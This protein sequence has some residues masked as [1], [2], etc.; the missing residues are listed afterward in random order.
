MFQDTSRSVNGIS[1]FEEAYPGRN[2][3]E[4]EREIDCCGSPSQAQMKSPK[5]LPSGAYKVYDR[6]L[7]RHRYIPRKWTQEEFEAALPGRFKSKPTVSYHDSEAGFEKDINVNG[8]NLSE[9]ETFTASEKIKQP[10]GFSNSQTKRELEEKIKNLKAI[11]EK[12]GKSNDDCETSSNMDEME[13]TEKVEM[14]ETQV[15]ELERCK[16]SE[17]KVKLIEEPDFAGNCDENSEEVNTESSRNNFCSFLNAFLRCLLK[18]ESFVELLSNISGNNPIIVKLKFLMQSI[19]NPQQLDSED[20]FL[21]FLEEFSECHSCD[22]VLAI[23]LET[24]IEDTS[25]EGASNLRS[26]IQGEFCHITTCDSCV[27]IAKDFEPFLFLNPTTPSVHSQNNRVFDI[28]FLTCSC[29]GIWLVTTR[30]FVIK[31]GMLV[32]DLVEELLSCPEFNGCNSIHIGEVSGGRLIET[33]DKDVELSTIRSNSDIFAFNVLNFSNEFAESSHAS[34]STAMPY[35]LYYNCGLCLSDG[36][37]VGL[38]THK[39]CGG[40]ICRD[41]LDMITQ[42]YHEWEHCPC[43]IC[44]QTIDLDKELCRARMSETREELTPG[45]NLYCEVMFRADKHIDGGIRELNKFFD[46][47]RSSTPRGEAKVGGGRVFK[48]VW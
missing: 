41:C 4:N 40:M 38:F 8:Y 3:I 43:P 30:Q 13:R 25:S 39:K 33:F 48:T 2:E 9:N 7:E 32:N 36:K 31:P 42:S 18:I 46:V 1:R 5:D 14:D 34:R 24:L 27:S 15:E 44:E 47:S 37:D 23:F 26:L 6:V 11:F 20:M 17:A 21:N 28:N 19:E 16:D 35:H 22:E 12:A 10:S 29:E 45:S